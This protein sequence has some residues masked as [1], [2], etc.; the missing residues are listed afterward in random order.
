MFNGMAKLAQVIEVVIVSLYKT[1]LFKA[2]WVPSGNSGGNSSAKID[3]DQLKIYIGLAVEQEGL[4]RTWKANLPANY[5]DD[6]DS[7]DVIVQRQRYY[8]I[9]RCASELHEFLTVDIS[10]SDS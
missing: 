3:L 6:A 10:T 1:P 9:A 7:Q 2:P 4:L 5:Q 8:L